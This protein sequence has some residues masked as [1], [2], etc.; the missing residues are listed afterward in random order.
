[1]T[2]R[3]EIARR[4]GRTPQGAFE[5]A[6]RDAA[7]APMVIRNAPLL[8]DGTP[9]PTRFWLVDPEVRSAIGRLE[10]TGGVRRAEREIDPEAIAE[11]HRRYAAERDLALPVGHDGPRP[12][13]GVGGTRQGVKCLHAHYAWFLAGGDDPVGR[14]V[15]E[16]LPT[17]LVAQ[18]DPPVPEDE[19]PAVTGRVAAVDIGTNSVRLLVAEGSPGELATVERLMRITRL[20]QGVDAT[21]RLDPD[22]IDRTLAVLTEYRGD[23]PARGRGPCG[24][25][26]PRRPGT[27][28][29]ARS[30]ST[31]PRRSI[32]VRPE[33]LSGLEEGQLSFAGATA[34][35]DPALGPFLVVDIG[36]GSTEFSYGMTR[37]EA[38]ISTE[39]GC[40]RFT[41]KY[42]EHDPARPEE[43]VAALSSPRPTSTTSASRS[44]RSSRPATFIGL[45]GTVSTAAAVELGLVTYDRDRIHHLR[46]VEVA[47]ED[48][49]RTLATETRAERLDEPGARGGPR[50]RD[51]RRAV[52][53]RDDHAPPRV[54]SRA[55]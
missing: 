2:E 1:M 3:D 14:W 31:R 55:S 47:V 27:R 48:V 49:F 32:G 51:R 40:V 16:Q 9:M 45:A 18:P 42:L 52:R 26:P 12:S 46:A 30:S 43:L 29:T 23:R 35:L 7:G 6:V 5:V 37:C 53:P 17:Y 54:W 4:L 19:G 44:P 15:D 33:L 34:D 38:S 21:G 8:D 10:S 11:A 25:P 50:R 28:P 39:I 13:G 36:G 22:A 20:G 41:E 24:S